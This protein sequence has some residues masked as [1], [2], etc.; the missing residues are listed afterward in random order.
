MYQSFPRLAFFGSLPAVFSFS[1]GFTFCHLLVPGSARQKKGQL[2]FKSR[3][4]SL[5][6]TDWKLDRPEPTIKW[7]HEKKRSMAVLLPSPTVYKAAFSQTLW[8][9]IL[10]PLLFW[11]SERRLNCAAFFWSHC[12]QRASVNFV[13]FCGDQIKKRVHLHNTKT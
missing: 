11:L 1:L 8:L 7:D 5:H 2:S 3:A 4:S 12:K 10:V 13:A 6:L 9:F